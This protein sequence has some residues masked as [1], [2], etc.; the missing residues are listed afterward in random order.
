MRGIPNVSLIFSDETDFYNM[1]ENSE[2]RDVIERYLAKS[3]PFVILVSTPNM[4]VGLFESIEKEPEETCIYRRLKLPYTVGLGT[5]YTEQEIELAKASPSFSREYDLHYGGQAGN[6]FHETDIS[7]AIEKSANY[8]YPTPDNV[9]TN[10]NKVM[11]IDVAYGSSNFAIVILEHIDGLIRVV[12]SEEFT[13]PDHNAMLYKVGELL[14]GYRG[15]NKCYIDGSAVSFIRSIKIQSGEDS[16]YEDIIKEYRSK[17]WD[18][19]STMLFIP[20]SFGVEHKQMLGNLKIL[21]EKRHLA[22]NPQFDK[23]L[24]ALRTATEKNEGILDK[25]VSAFNDTLDAL[26]LACRYF[27]LKD[28][29]TMR[30]EAMVKSFGMDRRFSL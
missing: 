11:G 30:R 24:V 16:D 14:G 1:N 22:I 25:D 27:H 8:P 4:P 3:S 12:Y 18:W 9:N 2:V 23:L 7:A 26:R 19:E 13:R 6:L 20:V 5:I 28:R 17:G 15:I 21:L 10:T 29:E